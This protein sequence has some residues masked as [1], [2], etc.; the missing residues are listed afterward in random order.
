[1][2][3]YVWLLLS[4]QQF[5]K[6]IELRKGS[7]APDSAVDL[8]Q[9]T[10]PYPSA[11]SEGC[12]NASHST[13]G[14]WSPSGHT[15]MQEVY[16]HEYASG[17]NN[18]M[19]EKR[20]VRMSLVGIVWVAILLLCGT[21]VAQNAHVR[22]VIVGRS[23][24]TMTVKSQDAGTVFVVLNDNTDVRKTEAPFD[25]R[26]KH[27]GLSVL[28]PGLPVRMKGFYNAQNQLVAETIRFKSSDLKTAND[29]QAGITPQEQ[30][31]QAH[32]QRIE[33]SEQ[34]IKEQQAALQQQQQ[35]L[36]QQ[37]Q[38]LA[39]AQTKIDA[40]K[41]AIAATNKRFRELGQYNTV[42]E[43]TVL[44]GNGKVAIEPQ[45]KLQLVRLAQ[46]A[47]TID[48]Y[49]IQVKGYAS[50]V[51]SGALNQKL[52]AQ[53]ADNVTDFLEQ[54]CGIPLTNILAPG[55]MG[56]SKQV[57]PDTTA[58]G[59]AENRRVVVRILQDKGIAGNDT[60]ANRTPGSAL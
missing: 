7:G 40:N 56:T 27:S 30:Q 26:E 16:L 12:R 10:V 25:L 17:R 33:Q 48:G 43:F 19:K 52:S 22:G 20:I 59:Q 15:E 21:A 1:M 8:S 42:E 6:F 57:K 41:E 45:Y 32:E 46:K 47:K 53:R 4:E 9:A 49:M 23:G 29:I 28:V 31:I 34:Q 5:Q 50:A 38:D 60:L 35:A 44:F 39:A 58:Q 3:P 11:H 13:T 24:A 18:A 51:G 54:Q 37:Q 14:D 2:K 36:Q 55:A